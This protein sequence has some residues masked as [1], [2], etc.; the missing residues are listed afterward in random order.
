M[1]V[2]IASLSERLSQYQQNIKPYTPAVAGILTR[3]VGL[4]LE[5][6]G[7]RRLLVVNVKLKP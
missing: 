5:A 4:T 3:V 7:L 6:K 1:S 2:Q